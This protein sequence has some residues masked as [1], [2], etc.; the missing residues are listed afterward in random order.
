MRKRAACLSAGFGLAGLLAGAMVCAASSGSAAVSR[1]AV[2]AP[3]RIETAHTSLVFTVGGD[4]RLY[5]SWWGERL[6]DTAE[7]AADAGPRHEA[8]V[9]SGMS[10]LS[11][12]AIEVTHADGN[13]SL[14]LRYVRYTTKTDGAGVTETD[15]LL[16]DSVYPFTVDLHFRAYADE[17][18][19]E[20]WTEIRHTEK[21]AVLLTG[22]ASSML[23]LDAHTYTLTQFHGG[24]A[25]EMNMEEVPLGAGTRILD[26]KLG[27]RPDMYE[28][29]FFLL[30]PDGPAREEDGPVLAGTLAWTGNFRFLFNVDEHNALR[31]VSG[32][33]PYRSAYSLEPGRPL[34]TPPFIF[35]YTR[36]GKG[37][38]SRNLHHWAARYGI[39]DG[40]SPRLTLLNNWEA[41]HTHFDQQQLVNL[42]GGASR[43]GVDLFLLDDGWFGNAYPRDN[44]KAGLG[45][46]EENRQKLPDG[47]GYLVREAG[48]KGLGFGIWI[49]PE[50]VNPAS[51]LYH[52][53]P[54]WILRL[55]NRAENYQRNQLVLDLCNP[56]VQDYVYHAVDDLLRRDT[57]IAYVK[58][59]C[60][61]PMTDAWS[62]YLGE[63]QSG[64]YIGYTQGFYNVLE[65]LRRD[66]PHLPMM[67]CAGGGGRTDYGA[68]RYFTEFWPSDN[69]DALERV[70]IQWGYSHFFPAFSVC[71]H[72]TSM[73]K[74]SLKFRTDVAMMGKLGYDIQVDR[75]TQEEVQFSA[76]AVQTYKRLSP[77]IWWGDLYRLVSPYEEH[78]AALMYVDSTRNH[79]VVFAYTLQT[80]HQEFFYRVPLRGLDPD[81]RYRVEE[82][83]LFPGTHSLAPFDGKVFSGD[84][85]LRAGLNLSPGRLN[86]LTSWVYDITAVK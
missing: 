14:D 49:E 19:T 24:Y 7:Y 66:Y 6:A 18:V 22:F 74:E 43:L 68:L 46:W 83:N 16:R 38:A 40:H 84:Y 54:D 45:D 64:L 23:H 48:K 41:T 9:G 52:A 5:Q 15:I 36:G 10:D 62:P 67:L 44:D 57:G 21:K 53:H 4:G 2:P 73:G 42:F 47:L 28:A 17:D 72:V 51:T 60:N 34:V 69:T 85:L 32:I 29:P 80:R 55:P 82:V 81:K 65:R 30:S 20:A 13:P 3:I 25:S 33:N 39:L 78:R 71:D 37:Q 70:Y 35:T 31:I 27:T 63:R 59:D 50:M 8:F 86:P 1:P 12:P 76:G 11:E 58:W 75:M 79:A 61:R 56:V 77:V 26:S